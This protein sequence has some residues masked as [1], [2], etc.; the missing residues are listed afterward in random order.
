[1]LLARDPLGYGLMLDLAA[2]GLVLIGLVCLGTGLIYGLSWIIFSGDSVF[3]LV[4]GVLIA[5][6]ARRARGEL[7]PNLS[8]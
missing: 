7:T 2:Y 3:C 1:M 5:L 6:L 8:H 4:F